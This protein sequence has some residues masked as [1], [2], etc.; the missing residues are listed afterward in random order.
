MTTKKASIQT[1]AE[2]IGSYKHL[3]KVE[4]ALVIGFIQGLTSRPTTQQSEKQPA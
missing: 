1:V 4:Q 3:T 2:T